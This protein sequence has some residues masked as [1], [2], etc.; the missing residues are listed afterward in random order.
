M[1]E[2]E[3][4]GTVRGKGSRESGKTGKGSVRKKGSRESEGLR[5]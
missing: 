5:V 3:E 2:Y 4:N 1:S